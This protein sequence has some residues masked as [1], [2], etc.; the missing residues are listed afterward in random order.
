MNNQICKFDN[1]ICLRVCDA[2]FLFTFHGT[3]VGGSYSTLESY[4]HA[5]AYTMH[6]IKNQYYIYTILLIQKN[7]YKPKWSL[8]LILMSGF[9]LKKELPALDP[10]LYTWPEVS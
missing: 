2:S 3:L 10:K 4:N 6:V 5:S 9:R 8:N 7:E 1:T